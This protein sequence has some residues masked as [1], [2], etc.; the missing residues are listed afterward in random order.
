MKTILIDTNIIL[1]F[2]LERDPFFQHA[3]LIFDAISND[4]YV[5]YTTATAL[6]DIFYI[7]RKHTQSSQKA[8]QAITVTLSVLEICPVDRAVLET[9]LQSELADFED[10]VQIFSAIAQNLD[11]IVTRDIRGFIGSPLPVLSPADLL[12]QLD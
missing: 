1:D 3:E 5:G 9:A 8:R 10:A 6:T 11:A 12:N 4:Q 2:L 7:A